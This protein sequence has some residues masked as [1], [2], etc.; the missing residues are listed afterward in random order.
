MRKNFGIQTYLYPQPVM[1]IGTFDKNGEADIMNAAWGGICDEDK[2]AVSLGRHLTTDN[3]AVTN[4]FTVA[5]ADAEHIVACDFAGVVSGKKDPDKMKKTGLT[6]LR[7]EFV[8]AP[9]FPELPVTL[10][11]ELYKILEG[12]L[13]IGRI[14]N[15]SCDERFIGADGKPDLSKFTPVTFDPVHFGYYALGEKVGQAFSDGNKLR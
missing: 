11:C 15:V 12:G 6:V 8:N 13:Y 5:C 7:S 4:A 14:V 2:I 9:V 3:I 1:M 10:E